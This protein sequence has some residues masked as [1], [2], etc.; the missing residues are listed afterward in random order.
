MKLVVDVTTDIME[1]IER[2]SYNARFRTK[3][4]LVRHLL[5]DYIERTP[6]TCSTESAIEVTKECQCRIISGVGSVGAGLVCGII[7]N[8]VNSKECSCECHKQ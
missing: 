4:E 3:S 6:I 7:R 5:M 2:R 1:G 8:G